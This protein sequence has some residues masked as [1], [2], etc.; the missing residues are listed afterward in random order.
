MTKWLSKNKALIQ[1]SLLYKNDGS[2]WFT[3]FHEAGH[4]ILHGKKEIFIEAKGEGCRD[5][6]GSEKEQEADRFAQD[7]LIPPDRYQA[8]ITAENLNESD[9]LQFAKELG[10]APGIVVGRLQHDEVIPFSAVNSLKKR[11]EFIEENT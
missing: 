10:I 11:F 3:F 2:F 5:I 1:L 6:G 4:I 8:F 7:L 9:I